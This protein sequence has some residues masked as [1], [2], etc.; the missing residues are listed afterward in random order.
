[1]KYVA[2]LAVVAA[3]MLGVSV[4]R[5]SSTINGTFSTVIAGQNVALLN[6]RWKLELLPGSRYTVVR[7]GVVMIRGTGARTA[8]EITFDD[9]SGPAAC[10][11]SEVR[12][13]YRWH[14]A[15]HKLTLT[16]ITEHCAGRRVVLTSHPLVRG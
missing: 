2:L 13:I 1:M 10:Q 14:V 16:P 7:N 5:A 9:T 3:A 11:G 15:G 8:T 6:G 12:A 4:G